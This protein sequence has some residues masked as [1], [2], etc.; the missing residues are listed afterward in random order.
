MD[1]KL[2]VKRL[3]LSQELEPVLQENNDRSYYWV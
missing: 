2:R 1:Q 3:F